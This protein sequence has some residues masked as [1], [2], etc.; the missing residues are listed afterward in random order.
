MERESKLPTGQNKAFSVFL[1]GEPD[2]EYTLPLETEIDNLHNVNKINLPGLLESKEECLPW[3]QDPLKHRYD[4]VTV[5]YKSKPLEPAMLFEQYSSLTLKQL[6]RRLH[7]HVYPSTIIKRIPNDRGRTRT[8]EIEEAYG[9]PLREVVKNAVPDLTHAYPIHHKP[10]Q[11][12][13]TV[14]AAKLLERFAR[15][16]Y[17]DL[18]SAIALIPDFVKAQEGFINMNY[19]NFAFQTLTGIGYMDLLSRTGTG[20]FQDRELVFHKANVIQ[21][22][23]AQ[24]LLDQRINKVA[25]FNYKFD[26]QEGP[27][28]PELDFAKYLPVGLYF[29]MLKLPIHVS[30]KPY[31]FTASEL[32]NH[33]KGMREYIHQLAVYHLKK[34]L[35]QAGVDGEE[36]KTTLFRLFVMAQERDLPISKQV[37]ELDIFT[38]KIYPSLQGVVDYFKS[39]AHAITRGDKKAGRAVVDVPKSTDIQQ[40]VRYAGGKNQQPQ[41]GNLIDDPF[42]QMYY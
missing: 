14:F 8:E 41:T 23:L 10:E 20:L 1:E 5:T 32:E 31:D 2:I 9:I 7:Q 38:K 13:Y 18:P 33:L 36:L 6:A 26:L 28:P 4:V 11:V 29:Y 27:E 40:V 34:A 15:M 3:I 12:V 22:K 30:G 21:V 16:D 19:L 42:G 25:P 39:H 24:Y 35:S 17:N 37:L